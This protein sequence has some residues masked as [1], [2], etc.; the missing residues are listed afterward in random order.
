M[1]MPS[2]AEAYVAQAAAPDR[3]QHWSGPPEMVDRLVALL[4]PAPG[5]L[6]L[7]VGCGVGGPARRLASL[8]GCTVLGID[9]VEH[10][11][12][13]AR[14]RRPPGVLLAAGTGERLPVAEGC[15]DQVWALGVVAHIRDVGA[16]ARGVARVLRPGGT[17]G[18]TDAF[19]GVGPRPRFAA[20]APRPWR[21]IA[22]ARVAAVLRDAGLEQVR[23]LPWPG[24]G[25]PGALAAIDPGL[26]RDLHDGRLVPA[27]LTA[28]SPAA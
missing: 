1:A 6:V 17:V 12:L 13:E 14:R 10:L 19:R 18:T 25:I 15:V 9:P 11:L 24:E 16:F 23:R 4:R 27:L 20:T 8:T 7:D 21:A 22:A 3:S 28:R 26:R 2:I 5:D